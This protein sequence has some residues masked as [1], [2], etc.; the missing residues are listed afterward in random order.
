MR[1]LLQRWPVESL[2]AFVISDDGH[3]QLSVYLD[4][5]ADAATAQQMVDSAALRG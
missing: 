4:D 3:L 1:L 5:L 2:S